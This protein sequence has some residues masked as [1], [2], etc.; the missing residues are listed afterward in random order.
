MYEKRMF[1]KNVRKTD[2]TKNGPRLSTRPACVVLHEII[3]LPLVP[4]LGRIRRPIP[5][6]GYLLSIQLTYPYD[7]LRIRWPCMAV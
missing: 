2:A 7:S 1:K 3:N 6:Y 4:D 5:C